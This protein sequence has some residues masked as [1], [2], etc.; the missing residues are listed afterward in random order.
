MKRM[1][2][3]DDSDSSDDIKGVDD[4]GDESRVC[5]FDKYLNREDCND[6]DH[7]S[8]DDDLIVERPFDN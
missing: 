8:D 3:E 2:E 5:N 6:S 4:C 7:E 1:Q